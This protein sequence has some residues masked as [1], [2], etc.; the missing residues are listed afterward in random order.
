[1][2]QH[3]NKIMVLLTVIL[4][5][6]LAGAEMDIFVP[7]FPELQA[8]FALS[9]F[10]VETLLS[11]NFIGICLS[12]FFVGS[13][14]DRY[15]RKPVILAGLFIFIVGTIC[16]LFAA[17][18]PVL[19]LG[20]LLQGIGVAAPGI[21]CFLVI[22]DNYPVKEQ[23]YLLA[24]LNGIVNASI[25]VA[26]LA[27]SYITLYF[28]WQGNFTALLLMGVLITCMTI[29]FLPKGKLPENKETL[30]LRGYLPIFQSST[31]MMLMV[32]L[33]FLWGPYWVFAGISPILYMEDLNVS[34]EHFGYYQGAFASVFA[35]GSILL[36]MT[37]A[38]YNHT[39]MLWLS[40][41]IFVASLICIGSAAIFNVSVPL[42]I[43][44][45]VLVFVIGQIIPS[46]ILYPVLINFQPNAKAKVSA[47]TRGM[48]LIL[49]SLCVQLAGYFYV[50]S[51]RNLG[52]ILFVMIFIGTV[53]MGI[54]LKNKKIV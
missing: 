8:Q 31:L 19:I 3:F 16:C 34:L 14:A 28:H 23:Q 26:P 50:G 24:M 40:Q 27:G 18:F 21:L 11:A 32:S 33:V 37:M 54:V 49:T 1:M 38:R 47:V 12:L 51:F 30:S 46:V 41:Y 5:D 29:M 35:I 9:P 44:L 4:M 13:L 7:S 2:K 20:R 22:A 39:K 17:S 25:G 45:A 10:W 52:I 43:T 36:G 53:T 48:M 15:G 42:L 6:I